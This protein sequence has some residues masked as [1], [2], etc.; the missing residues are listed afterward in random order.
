MARELRTT[1]HDLAYPEKIDLRDALQFDDE[2][3]DIYTNAHIITSRA[4][5]K[6][7]WEILYDVSTQRA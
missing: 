1:A 6:R 3:Y 4:E 5:N 2:A 7:L